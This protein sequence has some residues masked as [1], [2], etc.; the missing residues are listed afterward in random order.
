MREGA[1]DGSGQR[2]AGVGLRPQSDALD[3]VIQGPSTRS[4][5]IEVGRE[6]EVVTGV[7]LWVVLEDTQRRVVERVTS[8]PT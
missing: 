8:F 7:L 5:Q 3:V 6:E 2:E 1:R 4:P